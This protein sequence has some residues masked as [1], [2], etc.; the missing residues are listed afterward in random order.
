MLHLDNQTV[1][2]T[3]RLDDFLDALPLAECPNR[4]PCQREGIE[5][6]VEPLRD[7]DRLIIQMQHGVLLREHG[8]AKDYAKREYWIVGDKIKNPQ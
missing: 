1:C 6:I 8:T 7:T 2:I 3:K 4:T 5:E